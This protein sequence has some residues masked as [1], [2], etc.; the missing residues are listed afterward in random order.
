ML[1]KERDWQSIALSR[2]AS[3]D[4]A[5]LIACH[6]S[7]RVI[8]FEAKGRPARYAAQWRV[9]RRWAVY[10][11]SASAAHVMAVLAGENAA[12][13]CEVLALA[14]ASVPESAAEYSGVRPPRFCD[15]VPEGSVKA[16]YAHQRRAKRLAERG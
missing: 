16:R 11:A 2:T 4:Y 13:R 9:G 3:D 8:W 5:G 10:S 6:G 15:L 14:L 7:K 12:K 1:G